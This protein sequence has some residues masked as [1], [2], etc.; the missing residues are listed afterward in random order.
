LARKYHLPIII[1]NR[2][3]DEKIISLLKKYKDLKGVFH[4]FCS[5]W[6]FAQQ[7]LKLNFYLSFSGF[8][9][10]PS[11]SYLLETVAKVPA[12]RLVIETDSPL[13]TPK[14]CQDEQNQPKNVKI[15]AEKVAQIRS[16]SFLSVANYTTK[17]AQKLFNL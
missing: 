1:H 15:I 9:T 6:Q 2:N 7:I 10:Y 17:N 4:C 8:I 11:K 3:G 13:I 16:D 14:P 5:T 12:E